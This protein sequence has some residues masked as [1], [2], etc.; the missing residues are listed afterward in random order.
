MLVLRNSYTRYILGISCIYEVVVTIL[1]YQFKVL[2]A[3]SVAQPEEKKGRH[4]V[5]KTS[6]R[7][8]W[9]TLAKSPTSSRSS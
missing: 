5:P 3:A 1:D 9:A 4:S 7:F 6:L 2:G 8:C